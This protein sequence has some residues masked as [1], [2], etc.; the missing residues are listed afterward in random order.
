M[1]RGQGK[2]CWRHPRALYPFKPLMRAARKQHYTPPPS[3]SLLSRSLC[4]KWCSYLVN[5]VR[6][7]AQLSERRNRLRV[8]VLRSKH[9]SRL[10]ILRGC[11]KGRDGKERDR[12]AVS[13][14]TRRA[15]Q[16]S[17]TIRGDLF[18]LDNHAESPTEDSGRERGAYVAVKRGTRQHGKPVELKARHMARVRLLRSVGMHGAGFVIGGYFRTLSFRLARDVSA[19]RSRRASSSS[20]FKAAIKGRSFWAQQR[21]RSLVSSR[22]AVTRV[23]TKSKKRER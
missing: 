12:A 6:V 15:P 5:G 13:F 4:P 23:P 20:S 19:L 17:T 22:H 8:A 1:C 21:K 2:T 9:E 3:S 18:G 14:E 10:V 16:G 11:K 7:H